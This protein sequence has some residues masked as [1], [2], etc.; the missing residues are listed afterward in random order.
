MYCNFNIYLAN[1]GLVL[2]RGK[3][4]DGTGA[5]SNGSGK[6]IYSIDILFLYMEM[7]FI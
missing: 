7:V 1:L 6:V 3:S 5:D 4:T 2:V